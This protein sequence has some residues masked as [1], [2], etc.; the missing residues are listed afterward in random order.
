MNIITTKANISERLTDI[1]YNI[2]PR[3][4]RDAVE[5]AR[6]L[7][8]AYI[9]VD[10]LCI[11]QEEETHSDWR[12]E[13]AKMGY[14]YQGAVLTIS[15]T[16]SEDVACGF[17]KSRNPEPEL[18]VPSNFVVHDSVSSGVMSMVE[19]WTTTSVMWMDF[20]EEPCEVFIRP[21]LKHAAIVPEGARASGCPLLS[22]GWTFQERLL[23]TR[24]LHILPQELLWECKSDFACECMSVEADQRWKGWNP[25][26]VRGSLFNRTLSQSSS[27]D[28]LNGTYAIDLWQNLIR[29]YSH[30]LFSQPQDRL[31]ALSGVA[32]HLRASKLIEG[33]YLAGLWAS[34]LLWQLTWHA[35]YAA[36][37]EEQMAMVGVLNSSPDPALDTA[38]PLSSDCSKGLKSVAPSWSWISTPVPIQWPLMVFSAIATSRLSA[39]LIGAICDTDELNPLG[40]VKS[41]ALW[42]RADITVAIVDEVRDGQLR[43]TAGPER[44]EAAILPDTPEMLPS[45]G[46]TIHCALIYHRF[47]NDQFGCVGLALRP[48]TDSVG[49]Q[50]EMQPVALISPPGS[51]SNN[52]EPQVFYRIGLIKDAKPLF[53]TEKN[54]RIITVH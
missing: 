42:L 53:F 17:L 12:A 13:S 18:V 37:F 45:R 19:T 36:Y 21:R 49:L 15:A 48:L 9:W 47:K 52:Q 22:R 34:D 35:D 40:Q 26:Q 39:N 29:E 5:V 44:K 1:S 43:L 20:K 33:D 8:I 41:G 46:D 14:I 24:T 11:I 7:H 4:I 25:N 31:P 32:Q 2:F 6:A 38:T 27:D 23:A 51:S 3:T 10:S 50:R 30:R 16:C 54:R 28:L